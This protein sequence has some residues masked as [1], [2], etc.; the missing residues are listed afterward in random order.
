MGG[1]RKGNK[2]EHIFG[3]S[4]ACEVIYYDISNESS[5]NEC[6]NDWNQLY[7]KAQDELIKLDDIRHEVAVILSDTGNYY[8][9]IGVKGEICPIE[10][11]ISNMFLGGDKIISKILI[12]SPPDSSY[13][14]LSRFLF[15]LNLFKYFSIF[16]CML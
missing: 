14:L 8:F 11:A 15:I 3:H 6:E 2:T 4:F 1:T 5:Q 16:I 12:F 7:L 9:G 10:G 13:I